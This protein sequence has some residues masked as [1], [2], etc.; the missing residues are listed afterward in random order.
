MVRALTPLVETATV[1]PYR[2]EPLTN[3]QYR[4]LAAQ[5]KVD[6]RARIYFDDLLPKLNKN[7]S[8]LIKLLCL[9][10]G[11]V[12]CTGGVGVVTSCDGVTH[13]LSASIHEEHSSLACVMASTRPQA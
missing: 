8:E 10:P 3:K 13:W 1:E 11:I 9:H 5:A 12:R 2:V 7:P 4:V 6:K